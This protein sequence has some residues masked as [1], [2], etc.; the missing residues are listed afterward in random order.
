VHTDGQQRAAIEG[1][2]LEN[3]REQVAAQQHSNTGRRVD[4]SSKSSTSTISIHDSRQTRNLKTHSRTL[5]VTI[6]IHI[7]QQSALFFFLFPLILSIQQSTTFPV[8]VS[9]LQHLTP[10]PHTSPAAAPLLIQQL[11]KQPR[12]K[13]KRLYHPATPSITQTSHRT[14]LPS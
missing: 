11:N 13:P 8:L 2:T 7:Y 6:Y 14:L 9:Y 5:Q 3:S 10:A 4:R 12:Q 1:P